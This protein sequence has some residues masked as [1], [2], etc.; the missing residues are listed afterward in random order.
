MTLLVIFSKYIDELAKILLKPLTG[1]PKLKLI[2][3]MII[4]PIV[5]NSLQFWI[6][7]NIIKSEK[8]ENDFSYFQNNSKCE[9]DKYDEENQ[10]FILVKD[11]K[12]LN[13][14]ESNS[15]YFSLNHSITEK[16]TNLNTTFSYLS[17]NCKDCRA[18][19]YDSHRT[20]S[21]TLKN[22]DDLHSYEHICER[23]YNTVYI[24]NADQNKEEGEGFNSFSY[25]KNFVKEKLN[26]NID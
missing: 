5:F 18:V 8:I 14:K 2:F 7:D 11:L 24:K 9:K 10:K 12:K 4:F 15:I 19:F 20:M 22:N 26:N 21:I 6:T 17:K 16:R 3:V 25:N 23:A 1:N 13:N